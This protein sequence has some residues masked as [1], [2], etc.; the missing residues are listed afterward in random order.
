MHHPHL[1]LTSAFTT[2]FSKKHFYD[3]SSRRIAFHRQLLFS[4]AAGSP[5]PEKVT[6]TDEPA[7]KVSLY[8][9]QGLFS[10]YKPIEWTSNDVVSY[11]R[12]ILERDA[13]NRGANPSKVG[14]R[15]KN[16]Q[17]I[18]VG[19]GGTLDPLA[20]GVLVIGVGSGTKELQR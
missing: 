1:Q 6:T 11:I 4:T 2:A 12:G 7:E 18:R 13:R 17:V 15:K 14:S 9:E 19:H 5:N 3:S 10:V 16:S 8:Q 20:T